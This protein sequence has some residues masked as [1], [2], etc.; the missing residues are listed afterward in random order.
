MK[1][2]T[3]IGGIGPEST[4]EYYLQIVKRYKE[5]TKSNSYPDFLIKTVDMGK[6]LTYMSG[7]DYNGLVT[8]LKNR[9]NEVGEMDFSAI[10]SNT[11]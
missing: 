9:I 1:K 4:V 6:I 11:P 5:L 8:F 7:K 2:F 10:A 3:L